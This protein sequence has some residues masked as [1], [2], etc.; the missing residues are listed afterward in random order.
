MMGKTVSISSSATG[1]QSSRR[2]GRGTGKYSNGK[3]VMD[4][5]KDSAE[6]RKMIRLAP[7]FDGLDIS[8]TFVSIS[9]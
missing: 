9:L 1:T 5:I 3:Q 7:E 8:E 6:E 4:G 2:S